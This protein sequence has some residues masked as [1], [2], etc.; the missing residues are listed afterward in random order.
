MTTSIRFF[1]AACSVAALAL[2]GASHA[3]VPGYPGKAVRVVV[4]FPAGGLVDGIARV[5]LPEISRTIGQAIVV[6]NRGGASGSIGAA[7]AAQSAPDGYT[8]L[9]VLDS[10]AINPL[11]YKTLPYDTD[12][13]FT[14]ISL[15]ARAPMVAVANESFPPNSIRELVQHAKQNPRSINFAS[16]GA[17][18][19]S[20]LTA[21]LFN[22][23]ANVAMTHVPYKGGAPAQTDLMGGQ[24]QLMWGTAPYAQ[25]LVK[26][27]KLK[28][29]GQASATRSAAFP[30]LPTLAEQ[31]FA[32]FEA[33]GWIGLL[34]P[35]GTPPAIVSFWNQQLAKAVKDPE[36]ARR[37]ADQGFEV[38][39]SSPESFAGFMKSE[40]KTW[41]RVIKERSIPLQ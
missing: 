8:L 11:V 5:L 4:P 29:L 38:V 18:S 3:Q 36:I 28:P 17:G 25:S 32:G 15:I 9:M 35:A 22:M 24:V 2:A 40:Q 26:A 23:T 1:V 30:A 12:K 7:A 37:L 10:H 41:A 14:P 33:Y 21:E 34:A 20:H 27:G 13:D 19:A 6:D 16:V 39:V 31:G